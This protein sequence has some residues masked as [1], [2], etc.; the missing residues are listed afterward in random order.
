M[1]RENR[2]KRIPSNSVATGFE[3][4]VTTSL[5]LVR[6]GVSKRT[7]IPQRDTVTQDGS[8]S[9]DYVPTSSETQERA[10]LSKIDSSEAEHSRPMETSN[11]R[12]VSQITTGEISY[13]GAIAIKALDVSL[14]TR[15]DR[16]SSVMRTMRSPALVIDTACPDRERTCSGKVTM[17]IVL[18]LARRGRSLKVGV[19]RNPLVVTH[20]WGTTL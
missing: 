15:L 16:I 3:K 6:V 19:L 7:S 18:T 17:P 20:V 13:S 10:S 8:V 5:T 2:G 9:S 11:S 4:M 14:Q 12:V 1:N